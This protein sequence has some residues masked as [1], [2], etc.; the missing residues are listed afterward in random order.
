MFEQRTQFTFDA[1]HNLAANV[2][3][4]TEKGVA[5]PYAHVHGHSFVATVIL[6]AD[7]IEDKGWIADFA[8]VRA[9]CAEAKKALDHQ[10][11][12]DVEGLENPTLERL[13]EWIYMRL[14][15]KLPQLVRIEVERPTLHEMAA[16]YEA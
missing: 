11:L 14:K 7:R 2:R 15:P 3:D 8:T 10:F 6:C 9:E 4:E 1:A 12:N 16:F 13:A 5:H